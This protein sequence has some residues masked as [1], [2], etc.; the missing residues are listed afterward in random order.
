[1]DAD[2][3]LHVSEI[4]ITSE[5]NKTLSGVFNKDGDNPPI[6]P[7]QFG[8]GATLTSV[9]ITPKIIKKKLEGL[10]PSSA[11]SPDNIYPR[12]LKECVLELSVPPSLKSL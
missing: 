5:F 12:F 3:R 7:V 8:G 6:D 1:M 10:K 4:D 2:G 11:P 9:D